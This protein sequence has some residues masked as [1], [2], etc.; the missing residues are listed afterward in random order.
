MAKELDKYQIMT[1]Y[2]LP[3][4]YHYFEDADVTKF[5]SLT[6]DEIDANFFVLEGRDIDKIDIVRD[7]ETGESYLNITLIN[8]ET[9]ESENPFDEYIESLSFDYDKEDGILT[10]CINDC[11]HEPIKVEGFL[12]LKDV[13]NLLKDYYTYTDGTISGNGTSDAP[14]SIS[15]SERTGNVKPINDIVETLPTSGMNI[16][17]RYIA[18]NTVDNSGRYY[19]FDGLLEVIAA[20]E[21]EGHG[22]KVANKHDWD[23]MLNHFE[24]GIFK[25][26]NSHYPS[27]WLGK[28]AN[29]V[30]KN[31]NDFGLDYCGYV[32]NGDEKS[33]SFKDERAQFWTASNA[34]GEDLCNKDTEAWVKQFMTTRGQVYQTIVDNAIYS[35]IRL[36]KDVDDEVENSAEILGEIYPVS[37]MIADCGKSKMW[38]TINL[39]YETQIAR[40]SFKDDS[41]IEAKPF[42]YEWDGYKW[43]IIR[44]ED[45]TTFMLKADNRMY[46]VHDNN[47]LPVNCDKAPTHKLIEAAQY[48]Y[49]DYE[50]SG[51]FVIGNDT[52][53][54]IIDAANIGEGG[55][56]I[57]NDFARF[58]GALYRTNRVEPIRFNYQYYDWDDECT[59][60]GSNYK[61]I[62][63]PIS[64][65]DSLV[66]AIVAAYQTDPTQVFKVKFDHT[67]INVTINVVA[68]DNTE[69]EG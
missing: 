45:Y 49:D 39:N 56:N 14:L 6:G 2:N 16:G 61:R 38:T 24:T 37:V 43:V 68:E 41:E 65:A 7:E 60:K 8:G 10:V 19:N 29:S 11:D 27:K 22:W 13:K 4:N 34:A 23:N 50:Y 9:I 26:H 32:F 28:R 21:E 57:M 20:L 25:D 18:Y 51:E 46:Y 15:R 66:T 3:E 52:I 48:V 5:D 55:R 42:I 44:I 12:T 47:I 36:V 33:V 17:D 69:S 64:Q 62:G 40:N 63:V 53:E 31:W 59:L 58:L 30:L 54:Y 35:S 1:Y 67:V